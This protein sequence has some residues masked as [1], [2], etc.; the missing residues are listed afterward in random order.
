VLDIFTNGAPKLSLV[1]VASWSAERVLVVEGVAVVAVEEV[2][3][4]AVRVVG[5]AV[6][7]V[8]EEGEAVGVANELAKKIPGSILQSVEK[9]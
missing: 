6:R 1:P 8:P 7:V 4:L 2:V 3:V 5:L 9:L